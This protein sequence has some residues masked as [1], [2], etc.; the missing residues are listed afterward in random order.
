MAAN[1]N[2]VLLAGN[3]TRDPE[4]RYTPGGKAVASPRFGSLPGESPGDGIFGTGIPRHRGSQI[5]P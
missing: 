1:L 3:L 2:L 4:V 5:R